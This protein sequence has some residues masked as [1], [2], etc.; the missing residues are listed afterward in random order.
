[1]SAEA[2]AAALHLHTTIDAL[3][4]AP[5]VPPPPPSRQARRRQERARRKAAERAHR[6]LLR[7][8]AH[9]GTW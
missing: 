7:S 1:M 9:P 3:P 4:A 2:L 5:V 6:A 8:R